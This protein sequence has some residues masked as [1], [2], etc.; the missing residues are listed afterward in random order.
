[1]NIFLEQE[2]RKFL[3]EKLISIPF[4]EN[5][6]CLHQN[7]EWTINNSLSNIG[8]HS[9][10]DLEYVYKHA[11]SIEYRFNQKIITDEPFI[12]VTTGIVPYCDILK[13]FT[14]NDLFK[15]KGVCYMIDDD[16]LLKNNWFGKNWYYIRLVKNFFMQEDFGKIIIQAKVF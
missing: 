5:Y 10:Y 13:I 12:I 16:R 7:E 2:I 3:L 1:M 9:I 11:K 4:S 15:E 8:G 6:K 14:T